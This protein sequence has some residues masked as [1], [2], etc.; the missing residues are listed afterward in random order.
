MTF[1]RR[2]LAIGGLFVAL[3]SLADSSGAAEV[4][5]E[6]LKDDFL[7]SGVM[8]RLLASFDAHADA[9]RKWYVDAFHGRPVARETFDRF[10]QSLETDR[11]VSFTY[12]YNRDG[13]AMTHVYHGRSG[14]NNPW[15]ALP[16]SRR[17]AP[18]ASYFSRVSADTVV[19]NRERL[20]AGRDA[21]RKI[22]RQIE[23]DIRDGLVSSGGTLRG[24]SSAAPC[25]AC[26]SALRMLSDRWGISVRVTHYVEGGSAH[27]RFQ[28]FRKQYIESIY[29]AL[30]GTSLNRPYAASS[31]ALPVPTCMRTSQ[32]EVAE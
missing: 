12:E 10:G 21:E 25:G 5:K 1:R 26:E 2:K 22:A 17:A 8:A 29:A 6:P 24:F 16:S 11:I 30:N 23:R 20:P 9:A 14:A 27:R 32:V 19:W 4:I 3:V 13:N 28:N 7:R 31:G 18:Y 15:R